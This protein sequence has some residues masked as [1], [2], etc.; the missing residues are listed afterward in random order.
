MNFLS[1]AGFMK[2]GN[3][4]PRGRRKYKSSGNLGL[5]KDSP[6]LR[7]IVICPYLGASDK[8]LGATEIYAGAWRPA[9]GQTLLIGVILKMT[10]VKLSIPSRLRRAIMAGSTF[11]STP[12]PS[13][14]SFHCMPLEVFK[15]IPPLFAG[16]QLTQEAKLFSL[17]RWEVSIRRK[18]ELG[19]FVGSR[20]SDRGEYRFWHF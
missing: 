19:S 12:L 9:K 5:T 7:E 10:G 16:E 17:P 3:L 8:T 15:S 20:F 14:L 4:R 11:I 6:L 18:R 13:L 1:P 2:M